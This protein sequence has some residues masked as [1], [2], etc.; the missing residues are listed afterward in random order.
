MLGREVGSGV[1]LFLVSSSFPSSVA[2]GLVVSE[3]AD[4][5]L[6]VATV[7]VAA[8]APLLE[9]PGFLGSP[10]L[11]LFVM[12]AVALVIL[13]LV[14]VVVAVPLL[15]AALLTSPTMLPWEMG[16]SLLATWVLAFATWLPLP[17]ECSIMLPAL[18]LA[19]SPARVVVFLGTATWPTLPAGL[20]IGVNEL[21]ML[22]AI[23]AGCLGVNVGAMPL[24]IAVGRSGFRLWWM[25]GRILGSGR[26]AS[27]IAAKLK[28]GTTR[29]ALFG[30]RD[31]ARRGGKAR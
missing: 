1:R 30:R 7:V 20:L 17:W 28:A 31:K 19:M 22:A 9:L 24:E 12:L 18:A 23:A 8:A 15:L 13:I 16:V 14:A 11:L 6:P 21:A 4:E 29:P 2:A 26:Q 25:A 27:L 5:L 10:P 3:L